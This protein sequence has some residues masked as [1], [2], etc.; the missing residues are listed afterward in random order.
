MKP[1]TIISLL[2]ILT[3]LSLCGDSPGGKLYKWVDEKGVV[4]YSDR[5]PDKPEQV[6]GTLEER[7]VRD[8]L[9][10]EPGKDDGIKVPTRSPALSPSR[11]P[12][13]WGRAFLSHQ[14]VMR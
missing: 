6:E 2:V 5:K 10:V 8:A 4:H 13:G 11:I 3:F 12:R 14:A 9:P 7:E 1:A